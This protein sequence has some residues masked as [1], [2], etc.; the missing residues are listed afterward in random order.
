MS[1][2]KALA[3]DKLNIAKM[4]ISLCDRVENVGKEE[5]AGHQIFFCSRSDFQ[6][7]PL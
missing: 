5:N 3:D 6:S 7:F 1:K 2:L 4:T